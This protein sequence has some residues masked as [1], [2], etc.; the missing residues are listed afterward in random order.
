MHPEWSWICSASV[1]FGPTD[2]TSLN[3]TDANERISRR[4]CN[5]HECGFRLHSGAVWAS[6][7][8]LHIMATDEQAVANAA[9]SWE[10]FVAVDTPS[11]QM[12]LSKE[13][14]DAA[15]L[16]RQATHILALANA[17]AKASE[18][19]V[20][21]RRELAQAI[22]ES[23]GVAFEHSELS[24]RAPAAQAEDKPLSAK[25]LMELFSQL[26]VAEAMQVRQL[27]SLVIEPLTALVDDHERGLEVFRVSH[28]HTA[29]PPMIFTTH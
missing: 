27:Q 8:R 20:V 11:Y 14:A 1:E 22:A 28:R 29:P 13:L 9:E 4:I 17:S 16:Q 18:Q 21:A 15:R 7:S 10:A 25:G 26:E 23:G 12:S 24:T 3:R 5:M 19:A 6:C 2:R